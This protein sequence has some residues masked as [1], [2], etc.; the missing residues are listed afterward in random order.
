VQKRIW[1]WVIAGVVFT[2]FG[3]VAGG[4]AVLVLLEGDLFGEEA[5]VAEIPV[6]GQIMMRGSGGL[7]TGSVASAVD[8]VKQ[9]E[10]AR[11]NSGAKVVLLRVDSPGGSVN[12]SREIWLAVKRVQEAGKPVVVFFEETAASGGYYISA[13]ADYI[14]AMPGTITGSIGVIAVIP[15]LSELYDK[16]GVDYTVIK[17]GPYKDMLSPDRPLTEDER[18]L[19]EQIITEIYQEFV[20][21]V[22]EGRQMPEEEVRRLAD[23]R[24]YTGRQAEELGLVDGL[25]GYRDAVA[26][27]GELAGLGPEP[28]VVEYRR[29]PGFFEQLAG[30]VAA[31]LGLDA[32]P[33]PWTL[34]SHVELRYS[35]TW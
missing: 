7:F 21:V 15:N 16:I 25:G 26:K 8:V 34:P 19:M 6:Y 22:A 31:R 20:R 28:K 4:G 33:V 5:H 14:I 29:A 24:I 32:L 11:T 10:R 30:M 13:P 3:C 35:A 17:S 1:W 12:A 18:R 2:L 23:G 9:L 27:A